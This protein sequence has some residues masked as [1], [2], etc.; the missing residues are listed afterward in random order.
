MAASAFRSGHSQIQDCSLGVF[1]VA[2]PEQEQ[3]E[4]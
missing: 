2:E 1:C 4:L 3:G